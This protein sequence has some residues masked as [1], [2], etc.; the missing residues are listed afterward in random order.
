MGLR[1]LALYCASGDL[2]M[3]LYTA[4][5][6]GDPAGEGAGVGGG[7]PLLGT[8]LSPAL[9]DAP[10]LSISPALAWL[11]PGLFRSSPPRTGELGVDPGTRVRVLWE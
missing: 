8:W 1:R 3:G 7:G 11:C 10:A 2:C 5:I 4:A 9:P 6:E